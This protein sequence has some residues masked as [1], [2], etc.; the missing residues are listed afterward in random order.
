MWLN[1]I[2]WLG[3]YSSVWAHVP[4]TVIPGS[5]YRTAMCMFVFVYVFTVRFLSTHQF[6]GKKWPYNNGVSVLVFGLK[7]KTEKWQ[8]RVPSLKK[9][10]TKHKPL[11]Q[12]TGE[13]KRCKLYSTCV[14]VWPSLFIVNSYMFIKDI[15]KTD[16]IQSWT[17]EKMGPCTQI[18]K[19]A[20]HLFCV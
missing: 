13:V 4:F 7:V 20:V 9:T 15:K 12:T 16:V 6:V 19:R 5:N 11:P 17:G 14:N 8:S 2:R 3:V 18:R 10:K 1:T